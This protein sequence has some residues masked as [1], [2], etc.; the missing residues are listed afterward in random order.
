MGSLLHYTTP[1]QA[2]AASRLS[3]IASIAM[4]PRTAALSEGSGIGPGTELGVC[5]PV[6]N[7][8]PRA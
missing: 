1:P 6:A 4:V 3:A 7:A 2:R 5:A 8:I